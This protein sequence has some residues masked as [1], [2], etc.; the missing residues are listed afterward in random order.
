MPPPTDLP[1]SPTDTPP[2]FCIV[3]GDGS[4]EVPWP[5]GPNL[6][7]SNWLN[8]PNQYIFVWYT[9]VRGTDYL[10]GTVLSA[11]FGN[12]YPSKILHNLAEFWIK[13][14]AFALRIPIWLGRNTNAT[15]QLSLRLCLSVCLCVCLIALAGIDTGRGLNIKEGIAPIPCC[16][17]S[18]FFDLS[19]LARS[20]SHEPRLCNSEPWQ[21]ATKRCVGFLWVFEF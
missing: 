2:P 18:C 12:V 13:T 11:Q 20:E 7:F 19:V 16:T 8:W 6:Q 1:P 14:A 21:L 15:G 3:H 9:P 4:S 17:A 10:Q 5:L